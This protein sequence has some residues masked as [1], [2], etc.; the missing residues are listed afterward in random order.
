MIPR[1]IDPPLAAVHA[2]FAHVDRLT[3]DSAVIARALRWLTPDERARFDRYRADVDRHMFLLGRVMA[4]ALVGRALGVE[5]CRWQWAE[6]PRGRPEIAAPPTDL[7]FNLSHSAGLVVCALA[8][9]RDV[10]IDVEDLARRPVDRAIV[11]RYCAPGECADIDAHGERWQQ[12]FLVYWTLKEAYL[13]ARG[14][15]VALPLAELCFLPDDPIR[16]MFLGSLA[17][18]S[19]EWSFVLTQPTP[20]HLVAIA[21]EGTDIGAA[22]VALDPFPT[23]LLP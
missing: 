23:D 21:V 15:G 8:R 10:G 6:G 12:R 16:V 19:T 13:K 1:P 7:R 17:G 20:T 2:C 9:G 4:R 11:P 14:L 5:P 3:R 22:Q 18:T